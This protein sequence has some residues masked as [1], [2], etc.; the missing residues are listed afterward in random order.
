MQMNIRVVVLCVVVG[1]TAHWTILS[2]RGE[3]MATLAKMRAAHKQ[4]SLA[5]RPRCVVVGGTNG[6][7]RAIA[8]RLAQAGGSVTVIGRSRESGE[9]VVAEMTARHPSGEHAFVQMDA[10]LL[11]NAA[12][13]GKTCVRSETLPTLVTILAII[14]PCS[15]SIDRPLSYGGLCRQEADSLCRQQY[16]TGLMLTSRYAQDKLDILVLTQGIA[17]TQGRTETEE[18]IDMKMALHYYS[19][20]RNTSIAAVLIG[21]CKCHMNLVPCN[22]VAYLCSRGARCHEQL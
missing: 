12:E 13:F 15:S 3:N 4:L 20:V 14:W 6:I 7:G 19:R 9:S 21:A 18:G 16:H 22:D 8:L 11:R 10:S 2:S 5:S 1:L 17:T